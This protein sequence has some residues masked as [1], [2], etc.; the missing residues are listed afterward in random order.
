MFVGKASAVC[1]YC[2]IKGLA[3]LAPGGESPYGTVHELRPT[4]TAWFFTVPSKAEA[5]MGGPYN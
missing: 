3:S 2:R 4:T 1:V 5:F